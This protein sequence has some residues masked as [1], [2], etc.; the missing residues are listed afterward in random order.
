MQDIESVVVQNYEKSMLYFEQKHPTLFNKLKAL[1]LLLSEGKYPQKYDLEFKD[2][3]FDVVEL[4]SGHFLYNTDS[5]NYSHKLVKE[6]NFKKDAHVIETFYN[7]NFDDESV[8]AAKKLTANHTHAT[9]APIVNYYNKNIEKSMLMKKIHKFMFLGVGLG[10]HLQNISQ[11]TDADVFLVLEDDIELFRLSL[12]TCNYEEAFKKREVFFGI[13]QN[14][15]EFEETFAHFYEYAFIRNHYLKFSL[16]SSKDQVHV[17]K[18]QTAILS[19]SEHCYSHAALLEK[20]SRVLEKVSQ[21]Y[22]FFSMLKKDEKFF[23]DKPLLVL[24]AGPSLGANKEWLRQHK[25]NFIIVAPFATLRI[26]YHLNIAPDIIVHID[27]GDIFA[28]RDIKL[29]EGKE[30]FFKNSLFIFNAS[31][32]QLFFDTFDKDAIYLLEDRTEYK[33]NDNYLEIASVGEAAYAIALSLTHQDIYLLGLDMA[34]ADDGSSH[35]RAHST[36]SRADISRTDKLDDVAD[37]RKT[38]LNVKGNLRDKVVTMPLFTMSI[39]LMNL[40]TRKYKSQDQHVYNLSDGAYFDN[41]TPLRLEAIEFQNKDKQEYGVVQGEY[42]ITF[43]GYYKKSDSN[44]AYDIDI[45]IDGNRIETLKADKKLESVEEAFDVDSHGFE[46]IL[47]DKYL[48]EPHLLEFKESKSGRVLMDGSVKTISMQDKKFSEFRFMDSVVHVDAKEIKDMYCPSAIGFMATEENLADFEFVNY[49]KELMVRIPQV[50]FKAF[51]FNEKQANMIEKNFY[52]ERDRIKLIIP[53][54]IY[55]IVSE[56]SLWI[57]NHYKDTPLIRDKLEDNFNIIV[58][59]YLK[60]AKR[61]KLFEYDND[62]DVSNNILYKNKQLFDINEDDFLK[63]KYNSC[64]VTILI[65]T[66]NTPFDALTDKLD[67][68]TNLYEYNLFQVVEMA[69]KSKKYFLNYTN[70]IK[71]YKQLLI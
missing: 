14:V 19:R 49:I 67:K 30:D 7:H 39:T 48:Q 5:Y 59:N 66:K 31:V 11:K 25:N 47:E 58:I 3:Y 51:Y 52:N 23:D 13:A 33:L 15:A 38:V 24:G 9:T 20:G 32:P 70:Y 8:K 22:K 43:V 34:L 6:I 40:Q 29:Y 12:F 50:T 2:G 54:D 60:D 57:N 18:I 26:L 44:D 17:K 62:I 4:A 68:Q 41:T 1:E 53:K 10:L 46:F 35:S 69:L 27:E 45:Y 16:F 42:G 71:H 28:E 64:M 37:I 65:T 56:T 61:L 63:M 55:S 21:D 36:K